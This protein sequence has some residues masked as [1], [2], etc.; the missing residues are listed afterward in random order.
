[1]TPVIGSLP[2]GMQSKGELEDYI[3]EKAD[4][5]FAALDVTIA[6]IDADASAALDELFVARDGEADLDTRLGNM[7]TGIDAATSAAATGVAA[8]IAVVALD[9]RVDIA[10]NTD[11]TQKANSVGTGAVQDGALTTAKFADG[12]IT[13]AKV[14]ANNIG[15]SH[16]QTSS[17]TTAKVADANITGPKLDPATNTAPSVIRDPYFRNTVPGIDWNGLSRWYTPSASRRIQ[18]DPDNPFG[19]LGTTWRHLATG[20][21]ITGFKV[22][23]SETGIRPGQ[24]MRFG[25][26]VRAASG[27]YQMHTRFVKVD[28]TAITGSDPVSTTV[29]AEQSGSLLFLSTAEITCPP[30]DAAYCLVS[31]ERKTGS[32]DFNIY[33]LWGGRGPF[34]SSLPTPTGTTMTPSPNMA[35]D[36]LN[37]EFV[38]A[39]ESWGGVQRWHNPSFISAVDGNTD[40]RFGG[41]TLQI[42]NDAGKNFLVS[43][44]GIVPGEDTVTFL[45]LVKS[46]TAGDIHRL[47]IH[48]LDANYTLVSGST[49]ITGTQLF[50]TEETL[51][52]MTPQ[53]V[54]TGT[55]I[56]RVLWDFVTATGP[57]NIFAL[58]GTV[59]GFPGHAPPPATAGSQQL[60]QV[61]EWGTPAL[62][63]KKRLT[64][65]H[66]QLARI[67]RGEKVRANACYFGHSW[68]Q[69]KE[70]RDPLRQMLQAKYGNGGTGFISFR[71][72]DLPDSGGAY[73][74]TFTGPWSTWDDS[75]G[76]GTGGPDAKGIDISH[77]TATSAV[78]PSAWM[79]V[80][81]GTEAGVV[82]FQEPNAGSFR[83]R[84]DGGAWGSTINA[85]GT[86]Q[87]MLATITG[88]GDGYHTLEGELVTT[89]T[90]P[91]VSFSGAIGLNQTG[92]CLHPMGNG[93]SK[94][95]GWLDMPADRWQANLLL[96]NPHLVLIQHD[97]ND[98]IAGKN[99]GTVYQSEY[100]ELIERIRAVTD[101]SI[102]LVLSHPYSAAGSYGANLF[103][104]GA[105][106]LA[107]RLR[108]GYISL[109]QYGGSYTLADSLGLMD[110][111]FHASPLG[112]Q[113]DAQA[114]YN[115][116][117]F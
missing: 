103:D 93:G 81:E 86:A 27:T 56:I 66:A 107:A 17:V 34:L 82:Y 94:L 24:T 111:A 3:T 110:G 31:F 67:M 100:A 1:M 4:T 30:A 2:T 11:G 73:R 84:I 80:L 26:L 44:L 13:G 50:T 99:P 46:V 51:L 36:G 35:F 14:A 64:T 96:Y 90:L 83:M 28:G 6:A 18:N 25:A 98:K 75:T 85:A 38:D 89:S 39:N 92:V 108:V 32:A 116:L 23:N 72:G 104:D 117:A 52:S 106:T 8:N 12:S 101:A 15:S 112:G 40:N 63:N 29:T 91:G 74:Q 57:L 114:I 102:A 65:W 43:E 109:W 59:N 22:W 47:N 55:V 48:F 19:A 53:L 21:G 70:T 97:V 54:P 68:A 5:K 41:R 37:T 58:W 113:M 42:S 45:S 49:V 76:D 88:L 115:Y 7:Q 61:R 62:I 71:H 16:L 78:T 95:S 77:E 79:T 9:D 105:R 69:R 10:H 33:A 60:A 87:P 20:A